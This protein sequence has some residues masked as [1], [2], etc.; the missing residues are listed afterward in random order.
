MPD[1]V[2]RNPVVGS[3]QKKG[4]RSSESA[5]R[6]DF[7]WLD[8]AESGVT[9]SLKGSSSAMKI[10]CIIQLSLFSLAAVMGL[11]GCDS[12]A[13]DLASARLG[14]DVLLDEE[15]DL[16]DEADP[17]DESDSPKPGIPPRGGV[18]E[19]VGSSDPTEVDYCKALAGCIAT[20]K[21][22]GHPWLYDD[23]IDALGD[24]CVAQMQ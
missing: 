3:Q 16:E 18:D 14:E 23:C 12:D 11:S 8:S 4:E 7:L 5:F 19:L 24:Y 2:R 20:A 17:E 6:L 22:E 15:S 1:E 10:K 13:D 21:S 9:Q